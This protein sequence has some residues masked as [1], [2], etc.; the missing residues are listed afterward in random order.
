MDGYPE[1]WDGSSHPVGIPTEL[2]SWDLWMFIPE[3]MV[4]IGIDPLPNRDK[5]QTRNQKL[6]LRSNEHFMTFHKILHMMKQNGLLQ[7]KEWGV[8][9]C[10]SRR[11]ASEVS[12]PNDFRWVL[13]KTLADEQ[14]FRDP[15][16]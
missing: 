8:L 13:R 5:Q 6:G 1:N 14:G 10:F 3:Q 12:Q 4:S 7:A 9:A 16:L 11:C 2:H 15:F